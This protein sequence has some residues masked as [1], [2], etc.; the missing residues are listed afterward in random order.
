M[1]YISLPAF[2]YVASVLSSSAQGFDDR[3]ADGYLAAYCTTDLGTPGF[4]VLMAARPDGLRLLPANTPVTSTDEVITFRDRGATISISETQQYARVSDD[5]VETG[6]C[7]NLT[8]TLSSVIKD[9]ATSFPEDFQAFVFN[10]G[11]GIDPDNDPMRSALAS[12]NAANVALAALLDEVQ[13]AAAASAAEASNL[14]ASLE[15]SL[16]RLEVVK[17]KLTASKEETIAQADAV[18]VAEIAELRARLTEANADL[19]RVKRRVCKLD[20]TA[21]F[22]VCK[23]GQ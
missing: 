13:N 23:D 1:K 6:V 8:S 15:E 20:P 5:G 4:T 9:A 16:N 14:R 11:F 22:S 3:L 18:A 17:S 19:D 7:V 12:A 10:T 2:V 21:T